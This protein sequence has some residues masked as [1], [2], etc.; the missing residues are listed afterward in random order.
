V[1]DGSVASTLLCFMIKSVAG[2]YKALVAIYPMSKLTASKLLECFN[3]VMT[4]L[5]KASLNV[6]VISVDNAATNRKF[7]VHGLCDGELI[8]TIWSPPCR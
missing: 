5:R 4:L 7:I 6:A 1:N 3:E 2:K 8:S